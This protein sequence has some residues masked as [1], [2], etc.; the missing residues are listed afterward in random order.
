MRV[1][2]LISLMLSMLLLLFS[3]GLSFNVHYC[4]GQ[5]AAITSVFANEDVCE[6]PQPEPEACCSKP[7]MGHE[8]CCKDKLLDFQE[9]TDPVVVKTFSVELATPFVL[10]IQPSFNFKVAVFPTVSE[11]VKYQCQPNAPPLFK[12]YRQY[13]FYA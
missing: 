6:M 5:I 4:K 13:L 9:S 2:R 7:K 1:T 11:V 8:P 12:L 10:P 3:M